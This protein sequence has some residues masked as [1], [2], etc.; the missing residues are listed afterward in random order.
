MLFKNTD[1]KSE[2][3]PDYRLVASEGDNLITVGAGW[4][5]EGKQGKFVSMKLQDAREYEYEGVKKTAP[6]FK[7]VKEEAETP[8]E[9]Q[10]EMDIDTE[11]IPF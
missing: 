1:K 10:V 3:Q 2:N 8:K 5:K 11:N 6:G 4:V 7:V 9:A